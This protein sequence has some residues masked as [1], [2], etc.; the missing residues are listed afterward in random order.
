MLG[1]R[2]PRKIKHQMRGGMRKR[3]FPPH[4]SDLELNMIADT[5]EYKKA[6]SV[7]D[8]V[9]NS[10]PNR[11]IP[12]ETVIE[13]LRVVNPWFKTI[14]IT[15]IFVNDPT[16]FLKL[17]NRKKRPTS[18]RNL[19]DYF[20]QSGNGLCQSKQNKMKSDINKASKVLGITPEE[21][22]IRACNRRKERT[23]VPVLN[24]PSVLES[25]SDERLRSIINEMSSL[26]L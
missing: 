16:D 5:D 26:I 2:R 17:R 22:I 18:S 8:R 10:D 15:E 13:S 11:D 20:D 4:I 14:D 25:K 21:V 12:L 3:L 24:Q 23:N 9:N 19:T 6:K 7:L 1:I